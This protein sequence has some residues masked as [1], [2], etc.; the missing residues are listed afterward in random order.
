MNISRFLDKYVIEPPHRLVPLLLF[1]SVVIYFAL[2]PFNPIHTGVLNDPDNYMRLVEATNWMQ[3]QNWY[4]LSQP[5]LS[6]GAHTVIHWSRLVDVPFAILMKPFLRIL[7]YRSSAMLAGLLEPLLLLG[8]LLALAPRMAKPLLGRGEAKLAVLTVPLNMGL[9]YNFTPGRADH[10]N[11]DVLI[12]GLGLM[13]LQDMILCRGGWRAGIFAGIAFAAGF[14]IS[15][16]IVPPVLL[17]LGCLAVYAGWRGGFVLRNAAAFGAAFAVA[18]S[19]MLPAAL[20]MDQW[21]GRMISWFSGAYAI[22]A[23]L[24][25]AIFIGAWLLGRHTRSRALRLAL[26]AALS[27]FAAILFI[28][29]V[30]DVLHG[31][32]ADFDT[33]NATTALENIGEAEPLLT[34]IGKS[35]HGWGGMS[36]MFM[37]YLLLETLA[38]IICVAALAMTKSPRRRTIWAINA[39]FIG[40]TAA[41]ALFCQ[42]RVLWFAQVFLIGPLAYGIWRLWGGFRGSWGIP[43]RTRAAVLGILMLGPIALFMWQRWEGLGKGWMPWQR[44]R[45]AILTFLLF[46]PM[47]VLAFG[48][49]RGE[50]V[51]HGCYLKPAADYIA[52][53]SMNTPHTIMADSNEGA[54]LL[55]RT[56]DNVIGGNFDVAGNQDVYDF[57]ISHDDAAALNILRKWH[58]DLVLTCRRLTSD[59]ADIDPAFR[60]SVL[61]GWRKH[62]SGES[63]TRTLAERLVNGQAPDWLKPVEIRGS[64]DYLLFEVQLP[65]ATPKAPA[66]HDS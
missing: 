7:G 52:A 48:L 33:F 27:G 57:F 12:A 23:A 18:T 38:L 44:Y 32:F 11:W 36:A 2:D 37:L 25:G 55:F 10:H 8:L 34:I 17:F 59:Y 35:A 61:F 5:R 64:K 58:A 46:A 51:T 40:G 22:F 20:P 28:A 14:W 39:I 3:G 63:G 41:L 19:A 13:A 26:I 66:S 6:P 42:Y 16:E 45:V 31:P 30:P 24:A 62:P 54:E 29:A 1:T 9:L 47:P 49:T 60:R 43:Q 4:D 65:K 50:R 53:A 56:P 21:N 15:P